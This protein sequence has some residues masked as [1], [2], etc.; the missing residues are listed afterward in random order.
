MAFTATGNLA[1]AQKELDALQK[2]MS[3]P[4]LAVMPASFSTNTAAM[5][6]RIG[7]EVLAGSLAAKKHEYDV[8]VQHLDRAGRYNDALVYTE[9]PG[10]G[11]PP[12]HR[13]GPALSQA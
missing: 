10:R 8:A 4:A 2:I 13:L 1:E 11:G 5:I 12:R 9:P 6:L 7:P 3:D